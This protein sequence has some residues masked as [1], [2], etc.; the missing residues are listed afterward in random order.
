MNV[1]SDSGRYELNQISLPEGTATSLGTITSPAVNN[2]DG[3]ASFIKIL[4]LYPDNQPRTFEEAK[5]LVI[6]DYQVVVEEKWVTELK[7]KYPVK[8][9]EKVFQQLLK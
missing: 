2:T 4:K 5:G 7:K 9:D 3:S 1:Q 6:N 8:M